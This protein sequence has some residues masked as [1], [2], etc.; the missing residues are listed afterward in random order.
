[1]R[2][3]SIIY[4]TVIICVASTLFLG[5]C[6]SVSGSPNSRFYMLKA[7]NESQASQ[8]LDIS[9]DAIIAIGPVKIPEYLNRPQI[10]TQD[11]N[12]MLNFAQFDRWGETLDVGMARVIIQDLRVMLPGANL[13]MFPYN[14]AI[15]VKY[16]VIMEVVQLNCELDKDLFLAVQWSVIDVKTNKMLFVKRSEFHQPID[17]HNY[18]GLVQTLSAGCASLSS[19]IAEATAS[20]VK[21][22]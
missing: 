18:S 5:G 2:E 17:P 10:V 9:S 16:Q 15:P 12:G 1:M 20:L 11:K 22:R 13:E 3:K 8:R 21:S 4:F 6:I 14:F 7:I 19:D